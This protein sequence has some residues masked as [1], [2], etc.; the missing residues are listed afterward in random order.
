[1]RAAGRP[2]RSAR[3][4][5][6]TFPMSRESILAILGA[7]VFISPWLGLP[8]TWMEVFLVLLGLGVVAIAV[9]LRRRRNE[10][11]PA[12][13]MPHSIEHADPE[14]RPTRPFIS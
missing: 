12:Q 2:F 3:F 6:Y 5:C 9:T 1:M 7:L 11:P 4:F 10:L 13:P 14:H 8:P